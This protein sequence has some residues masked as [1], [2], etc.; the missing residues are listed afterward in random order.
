MILFIL[1]ILKLIRLQAIEKDD[2]EQLRLWRNSLYKWF[3]Q[4][5]PISTSQQITWYNTTKDIMFSIV[6]ND[7]LIGACGLCYIDLK[8]KNADLSIYIGET[9]IDNRAYDA[10]RLLFEYGFN[11]LGLQKIYNDIFENDMQKKELL[12][13]VGMKQEGIARNKYY[14]NGKF[15]NALLFSILKEEWI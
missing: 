8:N 14:R 11:E 7:K 4:F 6:E 15:N 2:I 10:I 3:R 12:K 1:R 5:Y 9:Y 13:K